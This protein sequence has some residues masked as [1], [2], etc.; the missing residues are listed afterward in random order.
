MRSNI[1]LNN[2][3]QFAFTCTDAFLRGEVPGEPVRLPHTAK[4]LPWKCAQKEMYE[5]VCGYT[6]TVLADPS[7]KGK[8]VRL[9]L[10]GAAHYPEVFL[11]GEP[12]APEWDAH[13]GYVAQSFLLTGLRYGEENR[14]SVQL[15]TRESLNQPPFGFL[16]DYLCY[17][18]LYREARL[19]ITEPCHIASVFPKAHAD[20]TADVYVDLSRAPEAGDTLR[21]TVP[22]L[23]VD[24]ASEAQTETEFSFK[25]EDAVPW[26][27]DRPRLYEMTVSLL[28][29]GQE[30][31]RRT[32][33][34]GFRDAEFQADGFYLN[35][36]PVHLRGL[37]RHQSYPYIGYAAPAGMQRDEANYLKFGLGLNMVRTSHYPQ[38]QHFIDR[39]DEI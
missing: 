20:G 4:L 15:D 19:E 27:L 10:D 21:L 31:D 6:R 8:E 17:G 34:I 28:H 33:K 5:T 13:C 18:G 3:W 38:S 23:G 35:G 36:K 37:N 2:D 24:L 16:I 9:I 22:E 12:V 7:W 39:C 14:L 11:N 25:A 29:E 30:A 26:D 1:P 32:M